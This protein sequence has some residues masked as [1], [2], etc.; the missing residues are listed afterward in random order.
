MVRSRMGL[1]AGVAAVTV[2]T[3]AAVMV[4]GSDG[5]ATDGAGGAAAG[6]RSCMSFVGSMDDGERLSAAE[7]LLLQAKAAD[8]TEGDVTPSLAMVRRFASG[9]ADACGRGA[10]EELLAVVAGDLYAANEDFYSLQG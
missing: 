6:S 3:V 2:A 1:I 7:E 9:L 8:G 5:E 10:G 4:T